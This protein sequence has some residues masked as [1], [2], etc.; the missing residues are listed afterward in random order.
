MGGFSVA[1]HS[2]I[3]RDGLYS[4]TSREHRI[5]EKENGWDGL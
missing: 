1:E 4:P 3:E 5:S 2:R